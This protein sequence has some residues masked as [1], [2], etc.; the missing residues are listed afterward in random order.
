MRA[1]A[2]LIATIVFIAGFG[3]SAQLIDSVELNLKAYPPDDK[4]FALFTLVSYYQR[5]DQKKT[6]QYR[7]QAAGFLNDARPKARTYARIIEGIYYGG[8]GALDSA[9]YWFTQ[10]KESALQM[11]DNKTTA[12]I[13]SSLGRTMI[14]AG[15]AEAAVSNLVEGL[16]L[17]DKEP[18]KEL[19]MKLRIN[20]VWAY[21]ELKRYRDGINLGQQALTLVDSTVQWMALYIYNNVA[22]CYGAL[23]RLDSARHFVNLGIRYA[24]L[25]HDYQSLANGHFI[26]GTIYSNA[27]KNDLAIDQYEQAK[28][29]REKVGNPLY[30]VSDL[31]S[32][33]SLYEKTG[34]YKKG[35]L[36]GLEAL[37]LAKKHSLLLKFENTYQVLAM[38]YEG[39]GD[40]KKA[41]EYYQLWATAKDSVY[42]HANA[43][44]IADMETKYESEKKEQRI[45]LQ[46]AT[47]IAQSASLQRDYIL[48]AGLGLIIVL[49]VLVLFLIRS[50]LQRRQEILKNEYE[51]SLRE[52]FISASI[53]S[54]ENERKRFAQDLHDGMGQLISALRFLI[55]NN[56]AVASGKHEENAAKAA[57]ILNDMHREI[58]GL[59]FNLM[60][61]MLIRGG[62]VPALQEMG[63]RVNAT[64][65]IRVLV[66]SFGLPERFS[67]LQEIA[68]YRII[69]EWVNN[70]LKYANA[71]SITIQLVGHENEISLTIEDDGPGF[72]KR[73]LDDSQGNGWI[74]I[75]SRIKLIK[76]TVE[77]DS[78]PDSK[79][80]TFIVS[81]PWKKQ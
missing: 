53:Q 14:A 28:P 13:C 29:F 72:D 22:V 67:E 36:A 69:Q 18:D 68:L 43:Q 21:L 45:A 12:T 74:N 27:G 4:A 32:L 5:S 71:K 30:I 52:A 20:L 25:N 8:A 9:E 78:Q 60:P 41:S 15:K 65:Q 76:A 56:G 46:N 19:N 48:I 50:R 77:I 2:T 6:L 64:G 11:H 79:G 24:E 31:Y 33:A 57:V 81:M 66:E 17:M 7:Q 55:V 73:K 44:A 59:A 34:N 37:A 51:L 35:L 70:V 39:L 23:G 42:Q 26:L 61:Q 62:L 54:Q 80:T 40:F 10:A 38:N 63:T 49:V 3:Q 75:Q 58:R 1:L 47:I 16:R